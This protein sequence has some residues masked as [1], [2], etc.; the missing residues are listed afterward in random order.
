MLRNW[1]WLVVAFV[2]AAEAR[3]AYGAEQWTRVR[4]PHFD[5]LTDS[6]ERDGRGVAVH[7]EQMFDV[8][9]GVVLQ[10]TGAND[11]RITVLALKSEKDVTALQPAEY[12]KPGSAKLAGEFIP[13]DR[14][15]ML[16]RLNIWTE[17]AF[18]VV[19]HEYTHYMV[20]H[21]DRLP[22]WLNE[23]IAEFYQN[24]EID[25]KEVAVGRLNENQLIYLNH[26]P[27]MPIE[28]LLQVD[29]SSPYYH[30]EDKAN[31]FYATSWLLAHYL[32]LS[33]RTKGTH[34]L[35][36]YLQALV[37]GEDS[38]TAA[39]HAFGDLKKLQFTLNMYLGQKVFPF[40]QMKA[41]RH[42]A[43]LQVQPASIGEIDAVR[44]D[45]LMEAGRKQEG[46]ALLDQALKLEPGNEVV[47]L[48]VGAARLSAGENDAAGYLAEALRLDPSDYLA[49]YYYARA[50]F[51]SGAKNQDPQIE[52]NLQAAIKLNPE[53]GPAYDALAVFLLSRNRILDKA[54]ILSMRAVQLEPRRLPYRLNYAEVLTAE[55]QYDSALRVLQGANSVARKVEDQEL[56][57]RRIARVG[58]LQNGTETPTTLTTN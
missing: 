9:H 37:S 29:E 42:E 15:Y 11:P 46:Q 49:H 50:L 30:E 26:Y 23:G 10:Q 19:Y 31:S 38:L 43:E 36:S 18:E 45:I 1:K 3:S 28:T 44:A 41:Q 47:Q 58:A 2:C 27:P 51:R 56:V 4:S 34:Y 5:V 54:Q 35:Q 57:R 33:D 8:F 40:V 17:H 16:I 20:R 6:T 7:L 39:R 53:F 52:G 14:N 32:V 12:L 48:T 24:T 22:V 25:D 21:V 55:R 13:G